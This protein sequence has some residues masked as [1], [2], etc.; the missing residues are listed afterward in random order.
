MK[1]CESESKLDL[2]TG[3]SHCV[4]GLQLGEPQRS[5]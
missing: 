3:P 2:T 5:K 4:N 1:H